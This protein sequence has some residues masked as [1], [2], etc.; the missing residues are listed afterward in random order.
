[1]LSLTSATEETKFE[2]KDTK[3]YVQVVTLLTQDNAKLFEQLKSG[4]K[5]QLE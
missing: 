1:M 5:K 4:F 3:R 2:I